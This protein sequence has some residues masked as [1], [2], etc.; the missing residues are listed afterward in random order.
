MIELV[1]QR[2][3]SR[4]KG[5][6]GRLYMEQPGT[7]MPDMLTRIY[8]MD[9]LEDEIRQPGVKVHGETCIPPG[10]YKVVFVDSPRFGPETLSLEDVPNFTYIRIHAGNVIEDTDGC[11]LVGTKRPPVAS[12]EPSWIGRSRDSLERLKV[13]VRHIFLQQRTLYLRIENPVEL[14]HGLNAD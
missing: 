3:P 8:L 1:L 5:T 14:P 2:E 6:F 9:T 4:N 11:I 7:L 12:R 10:R 13:L